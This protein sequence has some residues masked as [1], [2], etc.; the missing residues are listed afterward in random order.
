MS[1]LSI[2]PTFPIFTE[3]NGLPLENGYIWIGAA[4]LDPQG[5]PIAVFWDA[6]LTIPAAQPIRTLN[7]YA[8]RSGTPARLYVESDYSI[9][10]MD[11]NGS[12]V[13]S[14]PVASGPVSPGVFYA[15]TPAEIN[16]G[17]TPANYGYPEGDNRR[18]A[19]WIDFV[20]I[21]SEGV[22]GD[23]W[24]DMTTDSMAT[25]SSDITLNVHG[26]RS[27]TATA[28]MVNIL[29]TQG[30]CYIGANGELL[31]DGNNQTTGA[32]LHYEYYFPGLQNVRWLDST[33]GGAGGITSYDGAAY[34]P[35]GDATW[36][37]VTAENC[38]DIGFSIRGQYEKSIT[39]ATSANPI[40]I[41]VTGHGFPNGAVLDFNEFSG[42]FLFLDGRR[43]PIT[44]TGTDTFTI[45]VDGSG[46]AA[47]AGG[48]SCA[49]RTSCV[50]LI[51]C[52]TKGTTG[53]GSFGGGVGFLYHLA[54]LKSLSM[55][56]GMYE[57]DAGA[58]CTAG[59]RCSHTEIIGSWHDYVGRG[60]TIGFNTHMFAIV[61]AAAS[62]MPANAISADITD[63]VGTTAGIGVIT[64]NVAAYANRGI[65]TT[66]SNITIS[67][68]YVHQCAAASSGHITVAGEAENVL[69]DGNLV[70]R[71]FPSST[72]EAIAFVENSVGYYGVNATN[73]DSANSVIGTNVSMLGSFGSFRE[74]TTSTDLRPTD[75]VLLVDTTAGDVDIDLFDSTTSGRFTG[76]DVTI[77]LVAGSNNVTLSLRS[78][79]GG[80]T[81]NGS[82]ALTTVLFGDSQERQMIRC[83]CVDGPTG[84]WIT[85]VPG[86]N[87]VSSATVIWDP[88]TLA[89]NGAPET[90][91][92]SMPGVQVEDFVE[93]SFSQDLLGCV[94][95]GKVTAPDV[96]TAYLVNAT[97]SSQNVAN[98]SLRALVWR[99]PV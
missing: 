18:Y 54:G 90:Q 20:A 69:V 2:Q 81:I 62:N 8:S 5:N 48:A 41:T 76:F 37:N 23:M 96:V 35:I 13:Y 99:R 75:R 87:Y 32:C 24:S 72:Y 52:K 57:G 64:G 56:G 40:E 85:T 34:G 43:Y 55:K 39:A 42:D 88:A 97:G 77:V 15:R 67:G 36:I 68:N 6:A 98:G 58:F 63:G 93:L 53:N 22:E 47:Y 46:F 12:T 83:L 94:L 51:N 89:N 28:P 9:R 10:V 11:K 44:V 25:A 29:R 17:V 84:E 38:A 19:T 27:V 80:G 79:S 26:W 60:P 82:S 14:A 50:D 3:T 61:G 30:R 59:F 21:M 65:R 49:Y 95:F 74:L 4:N 78:G 7:G 45:P 92:I 86:V 33:I 91:T 66:A 71:D 70:F 16:A 31:M 1:A 73:S